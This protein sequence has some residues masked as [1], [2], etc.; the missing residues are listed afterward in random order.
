MGKQLT[1]VQVLKIEIHLQW[2]DQRKS[3]KKKS[4]KSN[5]NFTSASVKFTY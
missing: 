4:E 5:S 3:D 2:Q 1:E